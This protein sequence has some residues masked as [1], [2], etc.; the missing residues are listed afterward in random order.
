MNVATFIVSIINRMGTDAA[1]CLTGGM[2]MHINRAVDESPMEVIYC[3]HEQA[4]A[5]AADGYARV[6]VIKHQDLQLSPQGLVS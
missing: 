5:A 3:N 6:R 2:A 1:F 4:V